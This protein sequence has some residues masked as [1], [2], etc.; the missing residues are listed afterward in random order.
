MDIENFCARCNTM[1]I[2]GKKQ[3]F[4]IKIE[5]TA[6]GGT[7]DMESLEESVG[8]PEAA[9]L[10]LIEQLNQVSGQEALD[11]IARTQ[12]IFLCPQCYPAWI[13]DPAGGLGD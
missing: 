4:Q 8:D 10:A 6:D 3:F 1:L 2:S 13:E 5:S 11:Q 7:P 12:V 9:Y